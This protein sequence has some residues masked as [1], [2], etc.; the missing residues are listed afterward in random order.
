MSGCV[1]MAQ[2]DLSKVETPEQ[3]LV[4]RSLVVATG[5]VFTIDFDGQD[6]TP[7]T[8]FIESLKL[9][10]PVEWRHVVFAS[11]DDD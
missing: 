10:P 1:W 3:V 5:R 8:R 7:E 6:D 4:L 11:L 2:Y 9:P